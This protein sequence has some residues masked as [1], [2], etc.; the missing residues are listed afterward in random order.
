MKKLLLT[1][2]FAAPLLSAEPAT[3]PRDFSGGAATIF[4]ESRHAFSRQIPDL[5][6]AQ[7]S[8][9]FVGNSFFNQSWVAAPAST[10]GR[11]GLG[12]LFNTRSC[13]ACH[14]RDGRSFPP[15]E[16]DPFAVML[17]RISIPGEGPHGAP[18]PDPMYGGQIQG[19][20]LLN[21][22]AEADVV[23]K[24]TETPGG[25]ADGEKYSLRKPEYSL[26][27]LGYG[28]AHKAVRMSART[29]PFLIGLGLL[30]AIPDATLESLADPED[31]NKD[32]ISGRLNR[33]PDV[34]TG[35]LR[36]GRF[37]W[38]AEQPSVR[39]QVAGAFNGDMGLTT[40]IFPNE[41]STP[42][43]AAATTLPSGGRPEVESKVLDAVVSYSRTLAVPGRR[44]IDD[45]Q[46]IAGEEL[47]T[48]IGCNKCHLP[49]LKTGPV[50]GLPALSGQTIRPFT[51]LLLHDL[52]EGLAD[53][54]PTFAANGREWRTPPLWGIGLV[55]K[56]NGHTYFLH[57]GRARNLAEAILWHGGE[58]E[59]S[60]EG[61]H[62]LNR[63]Q[64]AELLRFLNTL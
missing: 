47:F 64:R 36:I 30:E 48:A 8:A 26:H 38:K 2:L 20:A 15:R 51:D 37:G 4:D 56:V 25:F 13:S 42:G 1:C 60:R 57:D 16:G 39:Q 27:K 18:L 59:A 5:T 24:Y 43:Q 58:A 33:V 17:L 52:G 53:H 40:S 54:R 9:F 61:F 32:G 55:E 46:V 28:P 50:A 7:R 45:P 49:E 10:A 34:E 29:A 35:T 22:P 31:K 62:K 6:A 3:L 44:D 21:A 63:K 23:A 11:D 41:N 19:Q 12:P 14:L